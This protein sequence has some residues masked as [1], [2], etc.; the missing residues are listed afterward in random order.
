MANGLS[1]PHKNYLA[2]GGYGF[3]IGDGK[4]NYGSEQIAEIYY[5]WNVIKKLFISPDYQLITH[6]A[7]NKD[8]GPVHIL[9]LRLHYEL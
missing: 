2:A 8:R 5:S 9:A 6:P 4:L 1:D 3:L 7:Y